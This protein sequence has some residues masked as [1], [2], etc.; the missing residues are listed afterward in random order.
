MKLTS[1]IDLAQLEQ[2]STQYIY[3]YYSQRGLSTDQLVYMQRVTNELYLRTKPDATRVPDPAAL[4]YQFSRKYV[5]FQI[6]FIISD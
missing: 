3:Q 5:L 6:C 1:L 4:I 2:M